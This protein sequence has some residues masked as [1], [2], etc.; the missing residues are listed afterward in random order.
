MVVVHT[1]VNTAPAVNEAENL[2]NN[3]GTKSINAVVDASEVYEAVRFSDVSHH[4]GDKDVNQRSIGIELVEKNIEEG[5]INFVKYLGY[6]MAQLG[7][8]PSTKTVRLHSE[9]VYAACGSFYKR[10]GMNNIVR[11]TIKYYEIALN[12]TSQEVKPTPK[13]EPIVKLN[14]QIAAEVMRGDYGNGQACYDKLRAEGY[15]ADEVQSRVNEI[16]G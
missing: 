12:G 14:E 4:A 10:K 15:D 2:A 13:P 16:L 9:F 8:Y 7:L 1:T 3:D 11:D 5:Y 6:V